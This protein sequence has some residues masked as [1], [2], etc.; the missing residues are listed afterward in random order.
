MFASTPF[1][2]SYAVYE[3]IS[4][5]INLERGHS[6]K[7]FHLDRM[8]ALSELAGNPEKCAPSVHIAGSKGKGSVTGMVSCILKAADIKT[9]SYFSPHVNDF[10]ERI[11]D[12]VNFFSKE[13]YAQAGIE[14]REAVEKIPVSPYASLFE[15]KSE[16]G[17]MPSFFELMTMW[18]FLCARV[19]GS[20]AMAVET[21]M[22]GRLDSTNI[23]TPLVSI[24][25]L[26]EKEHSEYLGDTIAAIAGEK[27]GIIKPGVPLVLGYQDPE[28][29]SVFREHVHNKKCPFLYFPEC[30]EIEDIDVSRSGT[31][32]TLALDYSGLNT[33]NA[34]K[35]KISH[36]FVP[37]PG[38]VMAKNAGLAI[39]AVKTAFPSITENAIREGLANFFLPARFEHITNNP[40][41]IIDGAHTKQ[42]IERC[43]STFTSLYGDGGVLVFGCTFGK[44][45]RSM[46]EQ[47]IKGFSKIIITTPGTFKKSDPGEIYTIFAETARNKGSLSS[48]MYIPDTEAAIDMAVQM[49]VKNNLPVLGTGSF[50]LAG[51]IRN[52][53]KQSTASS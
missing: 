16:T 27:A 25:T 50:Y 44:D 38:E 12:G 8:K 48:L 30:A 45:I 26:I 42:S 6:I 49:A 3:W 53:W 21:G 24:I 52:L 20:R 40:D 22:G 35:E 28:A 5:F 10:R 51:E 1:T 23:L 33:G 36:L 9:A 37:I 34:I 13:I 46:A 47:C 15:E 7:N 43:L 39:L 11:T 29:L 18:F 2:G 31:S 19:S 32:F 41:F 14:L 4:T 17:Q